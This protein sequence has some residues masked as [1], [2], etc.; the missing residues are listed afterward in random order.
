MLDTIVCKQVNIG[1]MCQYMSISV[2]RIAERTDSQK[3]II[4]MAPIIIII[5]ILMARCICFGHVQ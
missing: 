3:I 2:W 5:N 1:Y 4:K